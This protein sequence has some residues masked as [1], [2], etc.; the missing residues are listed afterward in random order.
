MTSVQRYLH[1]GNNAIDGLTA[2]DITAFSVRPAAA[3]ERVSVAR[4]GS[5][6][7]RL[8]GSFEGHEEAT[9]DVRIVGGGSTLREIGRAH[10]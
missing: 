7:V 8:V 3:V 2:D 6:Q 10:V 4:A 9:I 1:Q 5:G